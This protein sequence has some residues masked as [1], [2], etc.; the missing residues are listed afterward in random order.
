MEIVCRREDLMFG[1][2]TVSHAL[3]GR[4][5][6]PILGGIRLQGEK[7]G[8]ELA[9]TDLERSIRCR[10]VAQVK[11]DGTVVLPGQVLAQLVGRLP[12][13]ETLELHEADGRARLTCG[14]AR[15]DLPTLPADDFPAGVRPTGEPLGRVG[16]AFLLQGIAQTAFA[17]M[18]ASETTRLALTGVDIVLRDGG[19][20]LAATNGYRLAIKK[21][22]VEGLAEGYEA[23]FLVDATVLGDLSRV[24]TGVAEPEVALYANE[25]QLH[26]AAGPV[27]FSCRTIQ[28]QF[29]DFERVVPKESEIGLFAPRGELL[30]ALRRLE[31][32]AAEESG[33]VS[34]KVVG[35]E[36]EMTSASKDK[37]QGRETVQLLKT[38]AKGIEIAFRAEYL[39]DALRRIESD[40]VALWLTSSERAGLI[41]PAGEI[42]PGDEGFIYVCMPV[43]L[44]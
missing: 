38:P 43:R 17:A 6:M 9:A 36:L 5:A 26:F 30:D 12:E 7:D 13:V 2:R 21:V 19:A 3:G 41:E 22:P 37:G 40:Q 25:G 10:V 24:L 18:R 15:F 33:A 4:T 29:P 42:A 8:V 32:T 35:A 23:S 44:L 16:L 31:I 28:E 20:K 14:R 39:I 34:L 27:L 11:G 1:V